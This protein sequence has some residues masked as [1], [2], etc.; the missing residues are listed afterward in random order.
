M[1]FGDRVRIGFVGIPSS[2]KT[3]IFNLLTKSSAEVAPYPFTTKDQNRG[4]MVMHEPR[5]D[6]IAQI[7]RSKDVKYPAVEIVDVAGLIKGAHMGEG[8]GNEFLSY[9]R[10][11]DV[12]A[13]VLR[14]IKS[15]PHPDG[16]DNI[17]RDFEILRYE[18]AMSDIQIIERKEEKLKKLAKVG[19]KE[20]LIELKVINKIKEGV[21]FFS[22]KGRFF[23]QTDNEEEKK[24]KEAL[25]KELNPISAKEYFIIINTDV[26]TGEWEKLKDEVKS[27]N[28]NVIVCDALS[29]FDVSEDEVREFGITPMRE[30]MT[31]MTKKTANIIVF[32]TGFEGGELRGWVAEK[33]I[34]VWEAAGM[35]HSDMQRGFISAEVANFND[36]ANC[37]SDE[38]AYS[39]GIF[40]NVGKEYK[41]QDGDIIRI[42]FRK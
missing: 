4:I 39:R 21:E 29:E 24:A 17:K 19:K 3:T 6:R 32:F 5:I 1:I 28:E 26:G 12:I 36:Y 34:N 38:E 31:E 41:V 40:K 20:V 25:I 2:G 35:I 37:K 15:I 33:G 11:L 8:L 30:L 27:F 7:L 14:Y 16:E 42:N 22:N 23:V 18:I 10:P 9:I 13:Y